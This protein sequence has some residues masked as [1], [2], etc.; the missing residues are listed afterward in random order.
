[1]WLTFLINLL[2]GADNLEAATVKGYATEGQF[3][4]KAALLQ[5]GQLKC[6]GAILTKSFILTAAHCLLNRSPSKM[7]I[8]VGAI[9]L[10]AG[11]GISYKLS[12]FIMHP[13]YNRIN[14]N[15]DIGLIKVEE[16]ME[17]GTF[18]VNSIQLSNMQEDFGAN[19]TASIM[20]YAM[21]INEIYE[22]K[23]LKYGEIP[24]W[25]RE[26][27]N[28]VIRPPIK[29][30]M[31]CA[32]DYS[33]EISLCAGDSG[34]PVVVEGKVYAVVSFG[35]GCGTDYPIVLTRVPTFRSWIFEIIDQS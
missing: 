5:D 28:S 14:Q 11:P 10:Q 35:Y 33:G 9:D 4:F 21:N 30:H 7:T 2:I 17:L 34:G 13:K 27:C 19:T 23:K 15:Y 12:A 31:I 16:P 18:N 20:G 1:M 32:A 6:G 26:D 8:A 25:S 22:I 3:P 24:I 29:D